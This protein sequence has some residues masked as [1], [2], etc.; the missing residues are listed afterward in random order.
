MLTYINENKAG[1]GVLGLV[2]VL[3]FV[4]TQVSGC[5]GGVSSWVKMPVSPKVQQV[6]GSVP[7]IPIKD[8][9]KIR[10]KFLEETAESVAELD[11]S[12]AASSFWADLI[13]IGVNT[14]LEIGAAEI[15]TGVPGGGLLL[16]ALGLLGGSLLRKP[17]DA[18]KLSD[19]REE[20]LVQARDFAEKLKQEKIDSYNKGKEDASAGIIS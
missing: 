13:A 17:G 3:F 16:G 9:P 11:E 18:K 5:Q 8:Y 14:G 2:L 15:N 12:Y 7:V 10:A 19:Y 6:T 4:M 1:F 20:L